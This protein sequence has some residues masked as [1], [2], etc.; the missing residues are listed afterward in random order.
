MNPRQLVLEV[1]FAAFAA[2]N[3][4]VVYQWGYLG[5]L[6]QVLSNS[7][8]VAVLVDLTIALSLVALWMWRDARDRGASFAPYFVLT[9]FLGSIGPL[10][11]LIRRES[12]AGARAAGLG[13]HHAP[14]A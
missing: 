7:A 14:S 13:V 9:V 8:S 12:G 2:L 5:F 1:V 11:Y 4:Y 10:L 6:A 3:V